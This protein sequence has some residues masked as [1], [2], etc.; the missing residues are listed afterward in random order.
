MRVILGNTK[1]T[2]IETMKVML[3]LLPIQIIQK[4]QQIKAY[5]SAVRN[6]HNPLHQAVKDPKGC[7]LGRGKSWIGQ[8]LD[9]S[10]RRLNIASMSADR[11]QANQGLGE[12]PKP[13]T[14][15]GTQTKDWERYPNRFR[16]LIETLFPKYVRKHCREWPA[17]KTVRDQASHSRKQ[18]TATPYSVH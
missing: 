10:S 12:V 1:D 14:G 8:V 15:R 2:L 16:R 3:D 17:G 9:G 11:A 5:F 6:P 4:V 13:R 7:R 18:Q